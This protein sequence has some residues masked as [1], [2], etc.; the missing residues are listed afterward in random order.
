MKAP[1]CPCPPPG[2]ATHPQHR[3]SRILPK[4]HLSISSFGSFLFLPFICEMSCVDGLFCVSVVRRNTSVDESYEWDSADVCVDSEVLEATRLD[5][6]GV[7]K[8]RG[9]FRHHPP[10]SEAGLQDLQRKGETRTL[11]IH[12]YI[13]P[14]ICP[15]RPCSL[16][17]LFSWMHQSS[18]V[19]CV[20]VNASRAPCSVL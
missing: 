7:G 12:P 2:T 11:Y 19:L 10:L 1:P 14:Y 17:S 15:Y 9:E 13:H 3:E 18:L 4:C 8:G 16:D 5:Q 20:T 6:R